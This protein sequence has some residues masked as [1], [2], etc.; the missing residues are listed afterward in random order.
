MSAPISTNIREQHIRSRWTVRH[1]FEW[2]STTLPGSV[3]EPCLYYQTNH[4]TAY[5]SMS[6]AREGRNVHPANEHDESK[7]PRRSA[8]DHHSKAAH[9]NLEPTWPSN[10]SLSPTVYPPKTP[11]SSR[12][13]DLDQPAPRFELPTGGRRKLQHPYQT[14]LQRLP[15]L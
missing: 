1:T 5:S 14:C 15:K 13:L 10:P 9:P 11:Q 4:R 7:T 2:Q 6:S 8:R 3:Q 12:A